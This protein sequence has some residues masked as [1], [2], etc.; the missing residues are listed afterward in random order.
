MPAAALAPIIA[1]ILAHPGWAAAIGF[2]GY[3]AANLGLKAAGQKGERGIA[4]EQLNLQMKAMLGGQGAVKTAAISKRRAS[5]E[6]IRQMKAVMG[7]RRIAESGRER[8]VLQQ[9]QQMADQA[10]IT[11]LVQAMLSQGVGRSPRAR[12]ATSIVEMLERG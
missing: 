3:S 5:E 4:K 11:Q 1:W 9:Q 10:M 6:N 7:Q 12:P 8:M 2:G